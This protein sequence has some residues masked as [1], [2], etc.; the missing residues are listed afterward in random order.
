ML[1]DKLADKNEQLTIKD[2]TINNYRISNKALIDEINELKD[3]RKQLDEKDT[4]C[5]KLEERAVRYAHRLDQS[6]EANGYLEEEVAKLTADSIAL[7]GLL[8]RHGIYIESITERK[9]TIKVKD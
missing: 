4:I 5:R 9:D 7:Y 1:R 2:I 3:N 8:E 6:D